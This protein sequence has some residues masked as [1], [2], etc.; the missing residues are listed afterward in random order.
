MQR[1][2]ANEMPC[3]LGH[4]VVILEPHSH[5]LGCNCP[6]PQHHPLEGSSV[7]EATGSPHP[8]PRLTQSPVRIWRPKRR[9]ECV[10]FCW[11]TCD[12]TPVAFCD[13]CTR[14]PS[15]VKSGVPMCHSRTAVWKH[16]ASECQGQVLRIRET[17]ARFWACATGRL[18]FWRR[19]FELSLA[20]VW[21]S[22]G[23]L[24]QLSCWQHGRELRFSVSPK[25][26]NHYYNVI[27]L[28]EKDHLILVAT[29][30]KLKIE[31]AHY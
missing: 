24:T 19:P 28:N 8:P 16:G 31:F 6:S 26:Y 9:V 11:D 15:E 1:L 7:P 29:L 30:R 22:P 27:S 18:C 10:T 3:W 4:Y 23:P 25:N 17:K 5:S 20:S 14:P 21:T 2:F 13:V 12:S